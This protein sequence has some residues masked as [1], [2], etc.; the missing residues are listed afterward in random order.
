MK[1]WR[2]TVCGYIHVGDAPPVECPVCGA[3]PEFFEEI[4]DQEIKKEQEAKN[5][6]SRTD[7]QNVLFKIP[8]G[9]FI[10]SSLKGGKYDGMINNT[11]FQITDQPLQIL[12]G[13][14][15]QHL[16][17]DYILDSKVFAVNFLTADRLDLVKQFGFKSGRETDKFANLSWRIGVSGAPILN[18]L[19][20]YLECRIQPDKTIDAGTHL[21]FLAEVI[22]GSIVSDDEILT[23]GAYRARKKELWS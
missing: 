19:P 10:V 8:C 1:K 9:L 13:M 11:V 22:D 5:Q 6:D 18:A 16:T 4:T 14:D 12:L 21:V 17:T 20:G 3:G 7:L 15:K 2:C 23:Y